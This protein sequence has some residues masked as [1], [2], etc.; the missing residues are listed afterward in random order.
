MIPELE[1]PTHSLSGL[2]RVTLPVTRCSCRLRD[3]Y[4]A[5]TGKPDELEARLG[6][7]RIYSSARD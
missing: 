5:A 1:F 7:Q 3:Q 6:I 2:Q 4:H